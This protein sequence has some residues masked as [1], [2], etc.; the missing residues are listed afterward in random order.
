MIFDFGISVFIILCICTP[1]VFQTLGFLQE[2][3]KGLVKFRLFL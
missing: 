1:H 2:I 3:L